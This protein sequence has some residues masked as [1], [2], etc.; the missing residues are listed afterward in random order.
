MKQIRRNAKLGLHAT[1]DLWV[2]LHD[3]AATDQ[4]TL[5]SFQFF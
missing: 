4:I 2:N 5:A 1:E 3:T